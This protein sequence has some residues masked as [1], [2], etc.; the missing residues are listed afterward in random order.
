MKLRCQWNTGRESQFV[1]EQ[2]SMRLSHFI[3][4]WLVEMGRL[5]VAEGTWKQRE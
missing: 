2:V 4:N 3:H 1:G 5:A